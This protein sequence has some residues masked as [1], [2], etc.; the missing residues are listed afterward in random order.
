MKFDYQISGDDFVAAQLLYY[1]L[2]KRSRRLKQATFWLCAGVLFILVAWSQEDS[3]WAPMLM[4]ITGAWWVYAAVRTLFPAFYFRRHYQW[5]A[6]NNKQFT[7]EINEDGLEVAGD[8][9]M[10]RVRWA[11]VSIK[12]ED[13]TVFL[14]YGANTL[15]IFAKRYLTDAEQR[16]LRALAGITAE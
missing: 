14:L 6:L 3:G 11:G 10:W 1:N 13:K 15:F 8:V 4:A 7:A 5:T 16:E 2:K 9:C 12:A